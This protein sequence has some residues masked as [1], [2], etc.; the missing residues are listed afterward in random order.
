MQTYITQRQVEMA[1]EKTSSAPAVQA[2]T[3]INGERDQTPGD[4]IDAFKN[5]S[6]LQMMDDLSRHLVH[7]QQ[8]VAQHTEK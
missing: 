6:T 8:M 2:A 1:G 7:W 5:L 4:T 3:P